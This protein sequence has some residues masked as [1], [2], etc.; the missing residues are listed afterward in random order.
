[1]C[2]IHYSIAV[3][4]EIEFIFDRN[5]PTMEIRTLADVPLNKITNAFN[6]AFADYKIRFNLTEDAMATKIKS[7]NIQLQY[8]PAAFDG[9]QLAGFILTATDI[10]NNE[11]VVYNA[12]TGVLPAYRGRAIAKHLYQFL[13]PFLKQQGYYRHQLEV[14]DDNDKAIA[15]YVSSGFKEKRKMVCY[16]GR[17]AP[18]DKQGNKVKEILIDEELF[19]SFWNI[20]PSWQNDLPSIK[21]NLGEHRVIGIED[22]GRVIAYAIYAFKTGR[23]KQC[24]VKHDKRRMGLGKSLFDYIARHIEV[25]EVTVTCLEHEAGIDSF[26]E[27]IGLYSFIEMTEMELSV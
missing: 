24:A 18:S 9:E 26:L 17:F 16:K 11:K 15:T 13:L 27:K 4:E 10:I 1:M 6:E 14:F 19:Q 21:R 12:G 22:E 7:E 25:T 20:K 23:V 8:S 2:G 3:N 5:R